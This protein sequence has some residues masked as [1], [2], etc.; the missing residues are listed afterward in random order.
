MRKLI[1][2][3]ADK[4]EIRRYRQMTE[5]RIGESFY[6]VA[7]A[8]A[9]PSLIDTIAE[10]HDSSNKPLPDVGCR[11]TETVP[12]DRNCFRDSGWEVVNVERYT[13]D[14][15]SSFD[16]ICLCYCVYKPLN[17]EDT[18]VKQAHRLPV[19]IDSFGG[20]EEAFKQW[21]ESQKQ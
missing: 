5:T 11:L 3:K 15:S 6:R 13:P 10:H 2:F 21:Q 17:P 7:N 19:S 1:L 16:V 9:V 12:E 14:T 4:G 8:G 20:N 18:W